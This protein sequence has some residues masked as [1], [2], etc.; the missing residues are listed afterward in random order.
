VHSSIWW[1]VKQSTNPVAKDNAGI[2]SDY[3]FAVLLTRLNNATFQARLNLFLD[4]G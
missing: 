2:K 1:N 3:R 4:A